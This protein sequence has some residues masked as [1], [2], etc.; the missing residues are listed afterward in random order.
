MCKREVAFLWAIK[1][2]QIAQPKKINN[3]QTNRVKLMKIISNNPK[4]KY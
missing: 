2:L 3:L 4:V 1:R